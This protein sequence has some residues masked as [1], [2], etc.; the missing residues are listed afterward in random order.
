MASA[1]ASAMK[2]VGGVANNTHDFTP[3]VIVPAKIAAKEYIHEQ[4]QDSGDSSQNDYTS[5]DV[6]FDYAL[7]CSYLNTTNPCV[8]RMMVV[9]V[10]GIV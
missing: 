6:R 8:F 10:S 7:S 3:V 1:S 2:M 5:N 9:A 4:Q